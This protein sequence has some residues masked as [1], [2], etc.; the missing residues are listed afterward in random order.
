[1]FAQQLRGASDVLFRF[2]RAR[3]F[4]GVGKVGKPVC[5]RGQT[6]ICRWCHGNQSSILVALVGSAA[7]SQAR[8]R[9]ARSV[10]IGQIEIR[11]RKSMPDDNPRK[12]GGARPGAGRPPADTEQVGVRI[13]RNDLAAI[14]AWAAA[15][16][17]SR[18]EAIRRLA[19]RG[20]L[21]DKEIELPG[22]DG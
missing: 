5:E 16:G 21:A 13:P 19:K 12:K 1:M 3:I 7:C 22:K 11:Y 18:A 17:C 14:D 4:D 20:L 10:R 9:A 15:N 6:L 2:M 8:C